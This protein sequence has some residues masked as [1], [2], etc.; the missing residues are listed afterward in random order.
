MCTASVDWLISFPGQST[1][2]SGMCTPLPPGRAAHRVPLA[3]AG[4]GLSVALA[5]SALALATAG[6][7]PHRPPRTPGTRRSR[8]LAARA[9]VA[10]NIGHAV[11]A[12]AP[13]RRAQLPHAVLRRQVLSRPV[14]LTIS[15][16]PVAAAGGA[17]HRSGVALQ[18]YISLVSAPASA[19]TPQ[20]SRGQPTTPSARRGLAPVQVPRRCGVSHAPCARS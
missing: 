6:A 17:V 14:Q 1:L 18:Q 5:H 3:S 11:G 15:G 19:A 4:T 10:S 7:Q 12:R 9:A 13:A 8:S 20:A 2:P 16:A